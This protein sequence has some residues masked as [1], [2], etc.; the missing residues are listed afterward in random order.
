MPFTPEEKKLLSQFVTDPEGDIFCVTNMPGLVGAAYA[1]YSRAKGG[2]REVLLKEFIKEGVIDPVHAQELIE[3]VL[4]AYGDDSVGEL[5]GAHLSFENISILATKEIED[6][7]IGGSPIEQSTRYV[8]YDQKTDG[9]YRYYREPR[10]MASGFAKDYEVVMDFVFDTYCSLI[11]PMKAYYQGLKALDDAAYDINGDGIKESYKDLRTEEDQKAFRITY[12]NDV[13]TKACDA[14]R[15]LLPIAT[16]TNV[17]MFGNGRFFQGML[18]ALYTSPFT[19][20]QIIAQNAHR[21]LNKVIPSY[22]KRAKRNDYLAANHD[23]MQQHVNELLME[24]PAQECETAVDL[25]DSGEDGI[26][27]RLKQ[28]PNFNAST[29][30]HFIQQESDIFM[31]TCMVYPYARHPFRQLRN[32]VRRLSDEHRMKIVTLYTGNRTWRRDRPFRA[33]EAGYPYTFDLV[34]DFGTYKDLMRHRINTQLRQRFSPRLGFAMPADLEKAGFADRAMACHE[35]VRSLYDQLVTAFPV[36]ASYVTLHGNKVRWMMG[37]NDREAFHLLELRTTP[38]GHA[39]YRK[40]SQLMHQA[41]K[42][43]SPWRADA[44][45]FVD[46]NDYFWSRAD[47]EARQRAEERQLEER[48]KKQQ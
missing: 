21:E 20:A 24:V 16:Q 23:A 11:E 35:K 47:S 30:K 26:T 27:E 2:F 3:R 38:Q 44:M 32:I 37:M 25:L 9:K 36:E 7:R 4:I 15:C 39:S 46:Y 40:V 31:I 34:T 17:G 42:K 1:R 6:R 28:E 45:K 33:Y 8:L 18:S 29:V 5:E 22:V 48:L 43:R 41:I 14:L 19:E 12:N 10:I 13:R